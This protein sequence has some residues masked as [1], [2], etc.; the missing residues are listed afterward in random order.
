MSWMSDLL[1]E[2]GYIYDV[3]DMR[4]DGCACVVLCLANAMPAW[5]PKGVAQSGCR[6]K[7]PGRLKREAEIDIRLPYRTGAAGRSICGRKLA[8]CISI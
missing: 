3:V 2:H 1:C 4:I 5:C 8:K 6:L 7:E